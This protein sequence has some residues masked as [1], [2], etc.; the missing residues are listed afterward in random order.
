MKYSN[1]NVGVLEAVRTLRR[2][3]V[4]TGTM[5]EGGHCFI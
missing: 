5:H 3:Q 1:I 4:E 2:Q